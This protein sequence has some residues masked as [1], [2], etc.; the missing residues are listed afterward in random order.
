MRTKLRPTARALPSQATGTVRL[1]LLTAL[2]SG[3][4]A[5]TV[6]FL[7][8]S[9]SCSKLNSPSVILTVGLSCLDH[10]EWGEQH[11]RPQTFSR[12]LQLTAQHCQLDNLFKFSSTGDRLGLPP[13]AK[14]LGNSK[15]LKPVLLTPYLRLTPHLCVSAEPAFA[16]QRSVSTIASIREWQPQPCICV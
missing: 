6:G 2:V 9:S 3:S 10:A 7:C 1:L 11:H 5:Q 15:S 14:I 16:E 12:I 8:H 4:I 13:G